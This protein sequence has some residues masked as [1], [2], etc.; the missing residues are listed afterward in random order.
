MKKLQ[1]YFCVLLIALGTACN[2]SLQEVM[3]MIAYLGNVLAKAYG[4]RM[5]IF[6]EGMAATRQE[7]A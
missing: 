6:K 5:K 4:R 2:V 7:L 3:A 1:L